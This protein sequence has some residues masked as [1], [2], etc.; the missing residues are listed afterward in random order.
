MTC[1]VT[2]F[3]VRRYMRQR[4]PSG[5]I[6]NQEEEELSAIHPTIDVCGYREVVYDGGRN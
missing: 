2:A 5:G 1:R 3:N 6:G 4:E